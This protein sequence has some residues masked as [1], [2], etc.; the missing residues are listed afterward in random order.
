MTMGT[1]RRLVG[2]VI[3]LLS[4]VGTVGCLAGILGIWLLFQDVSDTLQTIVV[5]LDA[6]LQRVSAANQNVQLAMGKA[7]AA[8]SDVG[9]EAAD[10]GSNAKK[11]R[12]SART[13]RTLLQQQASPD[14]DEL[15]GRLATLSDSAIAVSSL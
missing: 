11:N 5:M 6:G 3:L 14:M 2:W 1:L 4:I 13:I 7:R 9:K 10:L 8:V 15:G 12:R